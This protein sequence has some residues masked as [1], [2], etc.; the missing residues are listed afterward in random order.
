MSEYRDLYRRAANGEGQVVSFKFTN[1]HPRAIVQIVHDIS[2]H[3]LRY[4]EFASALNDAGFYVCGNDLIGHGMSKQGH[5]GCFGLR[6]NS[7]E[8]LLGDIDSL[9]REVSNEVGEDVP[10]IIIGAGFGAMLSELYTIRYGNI[11]MIVSMEN[12]EIPGGISFIKMN[13]NNHIMRKGYNSI[14]ES[15]H[16]MMYQTAKLGG[17]DVY[18]DFYWVSKVREEIDKY[19]QD[20][21]CGCMLTASAYREMIRVIEEL[22]SKKGIVR[23]PDIPI[24]MVAGAEDQRGGCGNAMM[25]IAAI[26]TEKGHNEVAYKLYKD[27]YHDIL[28][29]SCKACV[30]KDI[31]AWIE[32]KLNRRG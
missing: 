5:P 32:Q 9:F 15:V 11:A 24:Y 4:R 20:D 21:N 29:D 22:R 26:L 23:L 8:G 14:S 30:T 6:K 1:V 28:H 27:C 12:L 18:S 2:E 3:S 16:N 13:A 7:Y 19:I 25:K 31:I 10:R 17:G